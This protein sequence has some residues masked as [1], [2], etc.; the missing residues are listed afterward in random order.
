MSRIKKFAAAALAA[1]MAAASL[2]GCSDTRYIVSYGD[3]KVNSGIYLYN[4]IYQMQLEMQMLSYSQQSGDS[5][6]STDIFS[7]KVDGKDFAT[8]LADYSKEKVKEYAAV[9]EQFNKLGLKLTEE[10]TKQV[11]DTVNQTWQGQS[12]MFEAQG[13]SKESIKLA[14]KENV[15]Y[16]KVFDY[17][18]AANG[19]EEVKDEE[20]KKHLTDNYVRYKVITIAKST[21]TDDKTKK[22]ENAEAEKTAKKYLGLAKGVKF[23]DFDKL[24]EQYQKEQEA[25]QQ[26]AEKADE[27]GEGSHSNASAADDTSSAAAEDTSSNAAE[28]TSSAAEDNSSSSVSDDTSSVAENTSSS[29]AEDASSEADSSSVAEFDPDDSTSADDSSAA[30]GQTDDSAKEE[31]DPYANEV[32]KNITS[33]SDDEKKSDSGKLALKIKEMKAGKAEIY[34][35]D[36]AYYV[37][38]KGD[39]S[40]RAETYIKENKENLLYEMKGDDYKKKLEG[41][42][43]D[44][45]IKENTESFKRY[46]P[47]SVYNRLNDYLTEQNNQDNQNNQ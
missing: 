38:L 17:Y 45:N 6:G 33:M 41:W 30:D 4:M 10:E 36:N 23:D 21:A 40:E 13:V 42:I 35:D 18:Y 9:V 2:A 7:Q 39:V 11:S 12:D 46:A 43:K 14:V 32:M 22:K 25:K 34:D 24:I 1:S 20:I 16:S 47:K 31:K 26:E 19:K 28:D 44:L 29:A 37:V 3:T 8:Y 27:N 5:S 15:M